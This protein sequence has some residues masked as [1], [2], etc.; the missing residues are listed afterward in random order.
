MTESST[1]V[2]RGGIFP[3]SVKVDGDVVSSSPSSCLEF[4]VNIILVSSNEM[5]RFGSMTID[6]PFYKRWFDD[7]LPPANPMEASQ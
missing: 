5:N 6:S 7:A 2:I 1:E 3:T 4:I